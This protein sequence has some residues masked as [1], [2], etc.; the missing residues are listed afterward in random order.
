MI[1]DEPE[2]EPAEDTPAT[3]DAASGLAVERTG[4]FHR[5]GQRLVPLMDRSLL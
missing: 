2:L 1:D 4:L 5:Q 3:A